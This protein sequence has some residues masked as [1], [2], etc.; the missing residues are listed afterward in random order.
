MIC[1]ANL[2]RKVKHFYKKDGHR[3]LSFYRLPD[4]ID[5]YLIQIQFSENCFLNRRIMK[6]KKN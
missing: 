2:K 5:T 1:I 4:D 6:I 3:K